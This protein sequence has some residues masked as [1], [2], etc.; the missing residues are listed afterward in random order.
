LW[1]RGRWHFSFRGPF[2][3]RWTFAL[4]GA[5]ASLVTLRTLGALGTLGPLRWRR[6]AFFAVLSFGLARRAVFAAVIAPAATS[7]TPAAGAR[8]L[9]PLA[10]LAA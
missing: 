1:L 8:T 10:A 4:L 3:A 9:V 5:F 6:L 2:L 7:P